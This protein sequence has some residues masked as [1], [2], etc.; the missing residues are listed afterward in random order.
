MSSDTLNFETMLNEKMEFTSNIVLPILNKYENFNDID[1]IID[2]VSKAIEKHCNISYKLIYGDF[3]NELDRL[4]KLKIPFYEVSTYRISFIIDE[5]SW[6]IFIRKTITELLYKKIDKLYGLDNLIWE[7]KGHSEDDI[8]YYLIEMEV[9]LSL[10][11]QPIFQLWKK[12]HQKGKDRDIFE[13]ILV[14]FYGISISHVKRLVDGS[15]RLLNARYRTINKFVKENEGILWNADAKEVFEIIDSSISNE[16]YDGEILKIILLIGILNYKS[17]I[18][19]NKK[20]EKEFIS[21][22][23]R[24]AE[25]LKE[26]GWNILNTNDIQSKEIFKESILNQLYNRN[27]EDLYLAGKNL[28]ID[29]LSALKF[30]DK[31]ISNIINLIE[32][33]LHDLINDGSEESQKMILEYFHNEIPDILIQIKENPEI[34]NMSKINFE[35]LK[36]LPFW[37]AFEENF[38]RVPRL[39]DEDLSYPIVEKVVESAYKILMEKGLYPSLIATFILDRFL[40]RFPDFEVE[41]DMIKTDIYNDLGNMKNKSLSEI[42]LFIIDYLSKALHELIVINFEK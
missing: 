23:E 31:A 27:E 10:Y 21:D 8:V 26:I 33:Q 18:E 39:N 37:D 34:Y 15:I 5:I 20:V 38:K 12:K 30:Q 1:I 4:N 24:R 35:E 2:D 13:R 40:E 25:L 6:I 41:I 7:I 22:E 42:D 14:S 17:M 19:K 3:F 16:N 9:I 11:I 32:D 28:L 36:K 29:I